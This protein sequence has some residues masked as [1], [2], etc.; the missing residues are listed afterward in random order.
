MLSYP[1]KRKTIEVEV[2]K[3]KVNKFL[4]ESQDYQTAQRE[5]QAALL[6]DILYK[7]GNYQGFHYI[8]PTKDNSGFWG[9]E[10]RI[11]FI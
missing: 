7:T 8:D 9:K 5:A 11:Q 1:M 10:C 4:R 3:E 6:D 2:I